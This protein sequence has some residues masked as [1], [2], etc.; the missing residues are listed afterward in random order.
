MYH[1][2]IDYETN[3]AMGKH[4]CF[5]EPTGIMVDNIS[6]AME[7]IRRIKTY[8]I[9]RERGVLKLISMNSVEVEIQPFWV[10]ELDTLIGAKAHHTCH[11]KLSYTPVPA[12]EE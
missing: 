2:L 1:I 12:G 10:G 6:D 7:N 9:N 5:N 11:A 8:S 4:A 3:G